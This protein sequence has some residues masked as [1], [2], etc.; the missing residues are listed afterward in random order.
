[1]PPI[2][3]L[4]PI[5]FP[6]LPSVAGV[7]LSAANCG[8]RYKERPDLLLATFAEGTVVAGVMTTTSMPAAPVE[9][10]KQALKSGKARALVVNSGNANAFTGKQ[11]EVSVQHVVKAAASLVQCADTEILVASTGVIGVPLPDQ[12]IT[13]ALPAL[14]DTVSVS[15]W[16]KAAR[17][18]MT[19]DTF[20]KLATRT[21]IIDGV[22]VTINGIAKGSGMIAP[23]MATMLS[24]IFTDAAIP[25]PVLQEIF[26]IACDRSFNS[27]TVD[28][29]TS[30]NDAALLFATNKAH[31]KAI[32][33]SSDSHLQD[34]IAQL[35]DLLIELAQLIVKDGEGASKF[36]TVTV[37]GAESEPAARRI[38]LAIAN[39][40]LVK[41]A[42]AGE[43][44]N[45]GRIVMAIGKSGEKALQE[46]VSI[47][48]GDALVAIDGAVN[49]NYIEA[50]TAT[51]MKGQNIAIIVDVGAGI[52]EATVWTC[53]LTHGYIA[54]N[55]DYRS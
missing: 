54:I 14:Y 35:Q 21:A 20:K 11:G 5:S 19:T 44:A 43:D 42:V 13:T 32:S 41:T 24:F 46:K 50:P 15:N 1:M 34:F 27:I 38:G 16:E 51:Y 53:D 7:A 9:W 28:S 47:T 23:N 8:I 39:S 10:C 45:W 4:A 52:A 3:P 31:H 17:S 12:K 29:D 6:E 37:K 2:S 26:A 22:P 33:S 30:T 49:P 36:I 18:I 25:Q 55:A 40:P 48:I